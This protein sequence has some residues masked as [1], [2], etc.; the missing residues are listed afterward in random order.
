M[1]SVF[2][3]PILFVY[4]LLV[5]IIGCGVST[6]SPTPPKAQCSGIGVSGVLHDSLTNLP[7]AKG[8]AALETAQPATSSSVVSFSLSQ[9]VSSDA[10]GAFQGCSTTTSQP[11][12]LVIVALDTSGK[13]Y[14]PF[15]EQISKT[16]N[17]GTIPMGSCTVICGFDNQEQSSVP[18][19]INGEILSAP[20]ADDG[21]VSAEYPIKALDGSS[22]IWMLNMPSLNDSQPQSFSTTEGGCS[23]REQH[24]APYSFLLPSQ[25]AVVASKGGNQQSTGAPV[26]SIFAQSDTSVTCSPSTFSATFEK[27][28]KTPLAGLP[29]AQISAQDISF[30]AC[31]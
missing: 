22:A 24:C 18:A 10:D 26:Y 16:T 19:T 7:V 20:I 5:A 12:V 17:L 28:G 21:L 2:L 31:H 25:N 9:K 11:T 14:P 29:G 15:L 3:K 4:V 27:D 13:A 30:T 8:W 1:N 6:T 23:D